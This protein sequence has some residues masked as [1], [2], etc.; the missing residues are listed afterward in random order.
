MPES[1]N[2]QHTRVGTGLRCT[3]SKWP[4]AIHWANRNDLTHGW[5]L[6][7]KDMRALGEN[8]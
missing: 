7:R 3:I 5:N 1:G 8:G 2:C 4:Y 6:P